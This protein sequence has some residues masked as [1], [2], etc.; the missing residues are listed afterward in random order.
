M[1]PEHLE[2]EMIRILTA[3]PVPAVAVRGVEVGRRGVEV[4]FAEMPD[5][6]VE[7]G[8]SVTSQGS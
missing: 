4:D 6:G 3:K 1:P 5:C 2:L 7:V 8:R